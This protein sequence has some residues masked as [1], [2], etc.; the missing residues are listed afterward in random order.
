MRDSV[1]Y[2]CIFHAYS[3]RINFLNRLNYLLIFRKFNYSIVKINSNDN[4]IIPENV[5]LH[6]MNLAEIQEVL[7]NSYLKFLD[8][9]YF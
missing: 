3:I 2:R 9:F 4:C 1:F 8:R 7:E 5:G 6:F